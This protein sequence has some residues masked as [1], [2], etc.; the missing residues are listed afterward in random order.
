MRET[1]ITAELPFPSGFRYVLKGSREAGAYMDTGKAI[2]H[3]PKS[4]CRM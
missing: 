3:V 4:K 1:S 2:S